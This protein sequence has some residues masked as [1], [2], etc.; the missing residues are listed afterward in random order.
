[1]L[2]VF[3][4]TKITLEVKTTQRPRSMLEGRGDRK[5]ASE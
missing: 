3:F 4:G 1:M 2:A 5:E